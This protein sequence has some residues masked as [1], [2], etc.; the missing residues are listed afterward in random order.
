[1]I[2]SIYQVRDQEGKKCQYDIV[3]GGQYLIKISVY[4]KNY[5]K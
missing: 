5:A 3:Q 1:M 2:N 4:F